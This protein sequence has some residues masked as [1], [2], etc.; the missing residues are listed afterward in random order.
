MC[1]IQTQGHLWYVHIF[2]K[3]TVRTVYRFLISWFFWSHSQIKITIEKYRRCLILRICDSANSKCNHEENQCN[4]PYC[5]STVFPLTLSHHQ[6]VLPKGR[7]FT[8]NTGNKVAV[9]SKGRSS[10]ANSGTKVGIL[11][12]IN[13]CGSFPLLSAPHSLFGIWTDRKISKNIPGTRVDL[14]I[15]AFLTTE[16]HHRG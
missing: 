4:I 15:W 16:I 6:S 5:N 14:A 1:K 11:P 10:T 9:L 3:F 12:G 2:T 7:S 13:G 8:A